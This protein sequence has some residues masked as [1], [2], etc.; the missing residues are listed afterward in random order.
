MSR[1]T[2]K[3]VARLAGVSTA[4]I[5]RTLMT[6][7]K[8]RDDT[9]ERVLAAI[10]RIG[11]TPNALARNLRQMR[12]STVIL[13]VRQIVN[14]FYLEIFRGVESAARSLGYNVLMSNAENS[15]EREREYFDMIRQRRA[16]GIILATGKLPAGHRR[17]G[18]ELPPLV[19]VSEYLPGSGLPTVR[20][21]NIIAAQSAVEHLLELGHRRIAHITGPLPEVLSRDRLKGY[22]RALERFG[23]E[24]V[25]RLVARGDYTTASGFAAARALLRGRHPPS[26]IFA[27]NDEMAMGAIKAA[28]ARGLAVP[29]QLS[30]VGFDD[31]AMASAW[32]PA[33]TTVAQPCEEMGS[34]AMILLSGILGGD[35]R[36][37]VQICLDTTLVVR[38]STAPK[39]G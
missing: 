14:P 34:R 38:E 13:M 23:I 15:P 7:D 39:Q 26:A 1:G 30:V 10:E 8:V 33:L 29:Q 18:A 19:V 2:M 12:T 22:R 16:D 9:R 20:V 21:D 35:Q 3:D 27:A 28:R 25:E 5:S 17:A 11:Y 31:I 37:D 24:P 32:D 36:C 6:P 4:T